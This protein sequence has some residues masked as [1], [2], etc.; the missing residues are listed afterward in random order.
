MVVKK[1]FHTYSSYNKL[2]VFYKVSNIFMNV[3]Q[4]VCDRTVGI[5][6]VVAGADLIILITRIFGTVWGWIE[7]II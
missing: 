3:E 7:N 4:Q 5:A 6:G 1:R 2:V